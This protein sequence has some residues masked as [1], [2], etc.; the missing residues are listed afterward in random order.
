MVV[1]QSSWIRFVFFRGDDAVDEADGNNEAGG[2]ADKANGEEIR[3][4]TVGGGTIAGGGAVEEADGNDEADG[5]D[6]EGK[7]I[8]FCTVGGG[9]II[10]GIASAIYPP[11]SA[12]L[13]PPHTT[14]LSKPSILIFF[15]VRY[16]KNP[17]EA[18]PILLCCCCCLLLLLIFTLY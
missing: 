2:V 5:V 12:S 11:V 3:G 10:G 15:Q 14:K 1:I 4:C 13:P 6:D 8:R 9:T 18:A 17:C 7:D 16:Y